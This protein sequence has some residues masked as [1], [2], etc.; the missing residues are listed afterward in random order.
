MFPVRYV[1]FGFRVNVLLCQSKVYDVNDVLFLV[2]LPADKEV[3]RLDISVDEVLRMH[4][5]HARYLQS[6]EQKLP[7]SR[8]VSMLS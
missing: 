6:E 2:A 4:V 1:F 8:A 5:L 3:F 7:A